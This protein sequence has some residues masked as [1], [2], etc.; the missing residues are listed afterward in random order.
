[1][2]QWIKLRR[3]IRNEQILL[4]QLERETGIHSNHV[5]YLVLLGRAI[6]CDSV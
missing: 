6:F 1:M 4:R 2:D 5:F 3:K